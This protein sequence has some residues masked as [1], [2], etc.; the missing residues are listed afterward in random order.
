MYW[1]NKYI[2]NDVSLKWGRER[3]TF[4][5]SWYQS[6]NTYLFIIM[7]ILK[8]RIFYLNF[9]HRI[10]SISLF[11]NATITIT[12]ISNCLSVNCNTNT[13][14]TWI[15]SMLFFSSKH[16]FY[17]ILFI[18]I[19][20]CCCF[21]LFL[22]LFNQPWSVLSEHGIRWAILPESDMVPRFFGWIFQGSLWK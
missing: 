7:H 11:P 5:L 1:Q 20:S 18:W 9:G 16:A 3:E 12:T 8:A 13:T 10:Y 21:C 4:L 22:C 2:F 19:H 15:A 6:A 14:R 17:F